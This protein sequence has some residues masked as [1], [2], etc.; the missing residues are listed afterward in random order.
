MT[1]VSRITEN[2]MKSIGGM[3]LMSAWNSLEGADALNNMISMCYLPGS[4]IVMV[5]ASA[6][7][8]QNQIF[9]APSI[10]TPFVVTCIETTFLGA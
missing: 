5:T 8:I 6:L 2:V 1:K 3:P 7:M 9:H 4:E 10:L